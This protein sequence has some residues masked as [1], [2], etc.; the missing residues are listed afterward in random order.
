MFL[1]RVIGKIITTHKN[2]HLEG[3][4]FLIIQP[5][6]Y[7]GKKQGPPIIALD[8]TQA[9]YEDLVY[10]VK[11]REAGFPWKIPETP[12]DV[13]IVGIVDRTETIV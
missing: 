12:V 7:D 10:Y 13:C 9:G 3:A 5:V 6:S 4:K 11:G 8:V 1:A 2:E